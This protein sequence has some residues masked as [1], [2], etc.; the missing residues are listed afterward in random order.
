MPS[1]R[2]LVWSPEARNDL[3]S[4]FDYLETHASTVIAERKSREIEN[5]AR[6]LVEWPL[7]GRPRPT[8]RSGLRS[9]PVPRVSATSVEIVRVIDGRRDIDAIFDAGDAPDG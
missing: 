1:D 2:R 5:A 8:L 3:A 4:I 6:R 9:W 7:T